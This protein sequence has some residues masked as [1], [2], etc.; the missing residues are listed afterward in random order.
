MN[1]KYC[2]S[3][4]LVRQPEF[5][6]EESKIKSWYRLFK[7]ALN[8]PL[9]IILILLFIISPLFVGVVGFLLYR[10]FNIEIYKCNDCKNFKMIRG[11]VKV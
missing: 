1:C 11:E 7:E 10:G 8:K 3:T 5:N 6:P 4:N 9:K 2:E